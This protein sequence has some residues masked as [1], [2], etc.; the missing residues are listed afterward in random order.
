M[1]R[2]IISSSFQA[3]AAAPA[4]VDTYFDRVVK[5]IPADIVGA[6]VAVTGMINSAGDNVSK[7]AVL[8]VC[9]AVAAVLT[10]IW[11]LKQTHLPGQPPA[12]KQSVVS[13]GAF[14]VW[15]MALNAPL[16]Q[17]LW[18]GYDSLYG[19]LLLVLYTLVVALINP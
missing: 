11:T 19:S 17:T 18:A 13:T 1:S 2:R 3:A 14:I 6:W 15:V 8:W 12:V 4:G 7:N 16:I 9:F 10:P 5:F